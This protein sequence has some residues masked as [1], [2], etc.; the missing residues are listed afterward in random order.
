[1]KKIEKHQSVF[2]GT[3]YSIDNT[4]KWQIEKTFLW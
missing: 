1:M 2:L 3:M 4:S